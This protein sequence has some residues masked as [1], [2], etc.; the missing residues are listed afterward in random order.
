MSDD[1]DWRARAKC[2]DHD[3]ELWFPIQVRNKKV[4]REASLPARAICFE[5]PVREQCLA[6]AIQTD[7][8]WA[9]AGGQDF[10][11]QSAKKASAN[12]GS[13]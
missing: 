11:A 4:R 6:W 5:C 13:S 8:K 9:I 3:P 2:R 7:E 10:G 12:G 1:I